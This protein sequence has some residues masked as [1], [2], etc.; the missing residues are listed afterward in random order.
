MRPETYPE[1]MTLRASMNGFGGAAG[2]RPTE[3]EDAGSLAGGSV[4]LPGSRV[5]EAYGNPSRL[6]GTHTDHHNILVT[7]E[8]RAHIMSVQSFDLDIHQI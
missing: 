1:S 5:V 2:R 4:G 8:Y 7:T 3:W 6:R